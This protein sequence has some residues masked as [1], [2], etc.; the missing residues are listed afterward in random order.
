VGARQGW[1]H[2]WEESSL[3]AVLVVIIYAIQSSVLSRA[4]FF[5]L[6]FD[7]I[8]NPRQTRLYCPSP[9]DVAFLWSKIANTASIFSVT[10]S[11]QERFFEAQT[12]EISSSRDSEAPVVPYSRPTGSV[13]YY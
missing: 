4:I 5:V 9:E 8:S 11:R 2:G 3:T 7:K 6:E 10:T 12:I 1:E 13:I